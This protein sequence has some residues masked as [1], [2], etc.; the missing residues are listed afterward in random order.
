M[1]NMSAIY[2]LPERLRVD[3]KKPWGN[4]IPNAEISKQRLLEATTN[5]KLIVA[6]GDATS[7]SLTHL[8]LR[9]DIYV[10]DGKEK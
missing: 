2:R 10:V 1:N 3:L 6:V 4:L 9:P 5:S 7:E 8:T